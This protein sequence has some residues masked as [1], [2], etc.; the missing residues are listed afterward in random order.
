MS[1][2]HRLNQPPVKLVTSY[3]VEHPHA[4]GRRIK[5]G[6]TLVGAAAAAVLALAAGSPS[7]NA[8]TVDLPDYHRRPDLPGG[9]RYSSLFR[10][11]GVRAKRQLYR[12]V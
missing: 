9:A 6:L 10:R 12:L 7:A 8:D 11:G 1:T 3:D 4:I 5:A 2:E